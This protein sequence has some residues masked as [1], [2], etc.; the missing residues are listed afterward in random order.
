MIRSRNLDSS[1][2]QHTLEREKCILG[3]SKQSLHAIP[4]VRTL[5][6]FSSHLYMAQIHSS[7]RRSHVH[8]SQRKRE[9]TEEEGKRERSRTI[10]P[11]QVT[12][13]ENMFELTHSISRSEKRLPAAKR[14]ETEMKTE[15]QELRFH[16]CFSKRL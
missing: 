3:M 1:Q 6:E 9:R 15:K 11:L 16:V 4:I 5:D 14:E 7:Q 2:Q 12:E 8:K 10:Y 13:E